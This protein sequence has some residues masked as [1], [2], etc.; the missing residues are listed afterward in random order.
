MRGLERTLAVL[1]EAGIPAAM[2]GAMAVA[3]RGVARSTFDIDLLVVHPDALLPWLWR[4][5]RDEGLDVDL[6]HGETG[7]P[8]AGVVRIR[9]RAEPIVDVVVGQSA[10]QRDLIE[11]AELLEVA[12]SSVRVARAADLVLLKLYA[13]GPTDRWDIER[14]LEIAADR[15]AFIGAVEVELPRLPP[16]CRTLWERILGDAR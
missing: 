10:W 11:R 12:G 13:G 5:L 4:P 15:S 8:L 1:R 16:E 7:D 3:T 2:I 9:A 6:R 14:L